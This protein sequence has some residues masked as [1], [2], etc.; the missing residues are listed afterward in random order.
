MG[1]VVTIASEIAAERKRL[2]LTHPEPLEAQVLAAVLRALQHHPKVAKA[3]RMNTGAGHLS[4]QRGG[5]SQFMRFG[6]KGSPDIHG[7]LTDGR[8]LY[9]EVKRPSGKVT[10]EQEAFIADARKAGCVAFVARSVDDVF[11]ALEVI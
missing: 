3:W 5:Q 9:A 6:F 1:A 8:A 11:A 4:H 7:Y 10:P 2:R